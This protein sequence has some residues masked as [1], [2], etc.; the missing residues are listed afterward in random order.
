MKEVRDLVIQ[1]SKGTAFWAEGVA[2]SKAL[3]PEMFKKCQRSQHGS[4]RGSKVE[5][6]GNEIRRITILGWAGFIIIERNLA[7]THGEL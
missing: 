6:D 4:N 3:M 5:I 2:I 1:T 7:S